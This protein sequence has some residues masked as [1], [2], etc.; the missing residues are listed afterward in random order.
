[1][2]MGKK[3]T[4]GIAGGIAAYKAA[5]IVSWLHQEGAVVQVAM[6]RS[7]CEFITPLTLKTLS[8]RPV[9][10]DIMDTSGQWHVP[11]I[12]LADCDLFLVLPATGNILAKAAHGIADDLL[13]AALL[14]A[15]G[16]ILAA[17]AMNVHMYE[18]PAT[19]ENLAILRQRG[20]RLIEPETGMLACGVKAKGRLA[21]ISEIKACIQQVLCPNPVLAGK[22]VLVTAGPTYEYIDPVRYIGNCSSGK[23]GYA[24]AAAAQEAGAKVLLISGPTHLPTPVGVERINVT[25]AQEMYDAVWAHWQETDIGILAAAVADYRPAV[26]KEL[27]MKKK[28][29]LTLELVGNPD[30]LASLGKEKGQRFLAG[31]AA[32]TNDILAY[33]AEKL[34][35]KNLD[36]I[37]ANDVSRKDAGFDVDTNQVTLLYPTQKGAE[38]TELPLLSKLETGRRIIAFIADCLQN[39]A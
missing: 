21:E 26:A 17:P 34:Q 8:G 28:D 32:E 14:A 11:H 20:W 1:M 7:A 5:E 37:V 35:R 36:L 13:S 15:H 25:S 24:V 29:Q 22:Q 18:N 23:M 33:A 30:I 27:K 12:D 16:L 38:K 10:V 3:I 2:F 9:A 19:Q 39:K 6:T 31:F 4:V